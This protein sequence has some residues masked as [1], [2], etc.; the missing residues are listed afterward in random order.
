MRLCCALQRLEPCGNRLTGLLSA[1]LLLLCG[2]QKKNPTSKR[3]GVQ[4]R[5]GRIDRR[6]GGQWRASY[7]HSPEAGE[8]AILRLMAHGGYGTIGAYGQSSCRCSGRAARSFCCGLFSLPA[9]SRYSPIA[10]PMSTRFDQAITVFSRCQC[11]FPPMCRTLREFLV[12]PAG[13]VSSRIISA[14]LTLAWISRAMARP[15]GSG[16]LC[17]V[18]LSAP[19]VRESLCLGVLVMCPATCVRPSTSSGWGCCVVALQVSSGLRRRRDA[20]RVD[21]PV[22]GAE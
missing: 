2:G 8:R 5:T 16:E 1:D 15:S 6:N 17:S 9:R 21:L 20:S 19:S 4:L 12:Q 7:F 22:A 14:G 10:R 13:A 3:H 18:L 11:A